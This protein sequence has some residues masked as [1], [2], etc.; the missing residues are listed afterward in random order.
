M[1]LNNLR[2]LIKEELKR[3]LSE[4]TD[5]K[6]SPLEPGKYEVSYVVEERGGGGAYAD[7][8]ITIV[9]EKDIANDFN[10]LPYNFWKDL[11]ARMANAPIYKVT[12]VI[13]A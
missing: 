7:S 4:N 6:E 12:K 9:T 13:R 10:N 8:G 1:K 11:A 3:T 5:V 2:Q